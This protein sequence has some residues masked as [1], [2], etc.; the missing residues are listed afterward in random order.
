M[1]ELQKDKAN[2]EGK[3]CEIYTYVRTN[4]TSGHPRYCGVPH[5]ITKTF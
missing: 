1:E 2:L 4:E 3:W 5:E